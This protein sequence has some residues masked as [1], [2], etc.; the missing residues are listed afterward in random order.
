[1]QETGAAHRLSPAHAEALWRR[2]REGGDTKAR[3]QLVLAYS[4]MVRFLAT[5]KV[6]ELP[7]RCELDD[8]ISCGILALIEAVDRFDPRKGASF[9]Q[10]AWTRIAGSIV[11]ELRRQDWASRSVRRMGR[12]IEQVRERWYAQ[13]GDQPSEE[14]VAATLQLDIQELRATIRDLERADLV[15]LNSLARTS[16]E[17]FFS[18]EIVDT[19]TAQSSEHDPERSV[20]TQERTDRIRRVIESLSQRERDVLALIHVQELQGAEVGQMLGVSESRVS[21]ILAGIRAKLRA[22]MELYDTAEIDSCN[23]PAFAV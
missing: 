15:S 20:L 4:P 10:Y 11:D 18:V 16:D 6:R 22:E 14:Q 13:T 21:Q 2:W 17:A 9:E 1:M 7:P 8:L 3:D 19:L 5:R 23:A 12:Q